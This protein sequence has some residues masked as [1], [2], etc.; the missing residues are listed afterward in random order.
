MDVRPSPIAGRWY[1]ADPEA[2]AGEVDRY[3]EQA[4]AR[5]PAGRIW[6]LLVPHAGLRYSGPVAAHAFR[7]VREAV[8]E[9]VALVGPLHEPA[10]APLLTTA[11]DAYRT[12]LG[13]VEVDRQ[14]VHRLHER[15]AERLGR[16]LTQ[17]RD[18]REHS[19]EIELPFLQRVLGR[20]HLLPVMVATQRPQIAV[21]L[22]E[23]LAD[24]LRGHRALLIASSDLSHYRAAHEAAVL[25]R[26]LLRRITAL[27]PQGV[28]AAE[29]EGAGYAC[30]AGA[31]AAVLWAA[32]ALGADHAT[33][34][35]YGTSAAATGD[36]SAVVGYGAAVIWQEGYAQRGR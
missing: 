34:L 31:I 24:V 4:S 32:Q 5:M 16:G 36:Y 26:E 14:A 20:F 19:L 3:L 23:A 11:H 10:R 8:P 15:L 22:G 7:C 33:V 1:P 27:D 25:D 30:G 13:L 12:P 35:C 29:A 6:G 17:L 2:L 18:D 21:A 9:L 28:L